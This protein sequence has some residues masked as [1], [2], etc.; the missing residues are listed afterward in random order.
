MSS[1]PQRWKLI[2]ANGDEETL[3]LCYL[4]VNQSGK[5][6]FVEN[7]TSYSTDIVRTLNVELLRSWEPI[8]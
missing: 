6:I 3:D 5:L 8:S 1:R 2:W 7:R 4:R